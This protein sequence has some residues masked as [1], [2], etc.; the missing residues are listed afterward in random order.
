[1][2]TIENKKP[3]TLIVDDIEDV[4]LALRR[5]LRALCRRAIYSLSVDEAVVWMADPDIRIDSTVVDLFL[6]SHDGLE[7]LS[8]VARWHPEIHRVLISGRV[9]STQ[10]QLALASGY[11]HAALTKPW[12]RHR[13]AKALLLNPPK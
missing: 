2:P 3:V 8:F 13:L 1:M 5:D 6:G 10:L 4:C 9:L 12:T 7:L 11:A